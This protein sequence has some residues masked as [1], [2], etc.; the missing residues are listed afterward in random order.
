MKKMH[1]FT[2]NMFWLSL[3]NVDDNERNDAKN[4]P[5]EAN[6]SIFFNRTE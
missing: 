5:K 1:T 2:C 4:A 6:Y 3:K